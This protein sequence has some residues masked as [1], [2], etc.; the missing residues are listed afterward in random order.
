[1]I[2]AGIYYHDLKSLAFQYVMFGYFAIDELDGIYSA[3]MQ[4]Q[5]MEEVLVLLDLIH[6]MEEEGFAVAGWRSAGDGQ[7]LLRSKKLAV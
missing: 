3:R 5:R 2:A 7:K 6:S 4:K 1:M